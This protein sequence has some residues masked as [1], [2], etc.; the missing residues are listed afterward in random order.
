MPPSR[1]ITGWRYPWD[2]LF[3][4]GDHILAFL[5]C[6][7]KKIQETGD[8]NLDYQEDRN[9]N[10]MIMAPYEILILIKM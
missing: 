2:R 7:T 10:D 5:G 6:G 8:L 9:R 3:L 1:L 4:R